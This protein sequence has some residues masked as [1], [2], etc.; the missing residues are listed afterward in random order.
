MNLHRAHKRPD[1][2]AVPVAKRSA[3]QQIAA[4]T[5]GV[6]TPGNIISTIGLALVIYGLVALFA[7]EYWL[8]LSLL[9]IGR[10]L[11]IADGAAADVTGTKSPLGELVDAT[12]DKLGTFLTLTV[13][14]MTD[15]TYWWLVALLLLPQV[16]IAF[17]ILYKRRGGV[18][19]HPTRAGKLSM[20]LVWAGLIG[21][22]LIR[23]LEVTWPHPVTL[24]VMFAIIA[25]SMLGLYALWQ[26]ATGR[27]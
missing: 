26:Y 13:F 10:L 4:A 16:I 11:D 14:F 18:H 20:G 2:E 8:G 9:L 21:A 1:W 19:I 25:S 7:Q 15:I 17:L 27:D 5:H 6:V 12:A 3:F 22:V 23:A 24:V